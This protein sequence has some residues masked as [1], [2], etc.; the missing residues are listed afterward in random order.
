MN[1]KESYRYANYLDD[2]LNKASSYLRNDKFVT[3]TK[4]EH[5]RSKVNSEAT[6]EVI[7]VQ[8]PYDVEFTP[9]DVINFAVKV[10]AEKEKLADAIA[11]AKANAEI[12]IDTAIA[13]NKKKQY[14]ANTLEAL[15]NIK[16][17]QRTTSGK[18][19][20]FN[21]NNEQVPYTYDIEETTTIDFNRNDVRNLVKKYLK[22]ADEISAKLDAIEINTQV[23]FECS[24]DVN[25]N[26]EDIV[27]G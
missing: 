25:D 9:N 21:I 23:L 5:L 11:I 22:E 14:F 12:N 24:W 15:S 3:T 10:L 7:D 16:P 6:D 2:L 27:V 17:R 8:K 26:F 1:L 18:A 13:L 19:Y 20:R 4:Q